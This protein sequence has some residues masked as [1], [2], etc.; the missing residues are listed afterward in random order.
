[1]TPGWLGLPPRVSYATS[2]L[3]EAGIPV[4]ELMHAFQHNFEWWRTHR[5]DHPNMTQVMFLDQASLREAL[6]EDTLPCPHGHGEQEVVEFSSSDGFAG[7]TIFFADLACGCMLHDAS[8]D[9]EA[10]R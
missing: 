9:V 10:A 5:V 3:L 4:G 1:M 6:A 7:G 8:E 2:S